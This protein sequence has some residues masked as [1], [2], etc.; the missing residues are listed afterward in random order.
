MKKK[1]GGFCDRFRNRVIFPI[2]NNKGEIV[3]FGG[4]IIDDN[5]EQAKYLNSPET[6]L[7]KKRE[8]LYGLYESKKSIADQRNAII[9]EGYTDVIGL[10]QNKIGNS[11]ATLGTA[12]T[13]F[14]VNKIFRISD[15]N[16][17][18]L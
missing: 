18:L 16:N 5:D 7:F 4:R 3:G 14:H 15:E 2:R 12:I 6:L 13:E 11:L 17:I 8:L 9:V 10:Y 1:N